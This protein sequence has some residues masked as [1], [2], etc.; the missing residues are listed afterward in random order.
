MVLAFAF[1]F[2]LGEFGPVSVRHTGAA[3]GEEV[4][5]GGV[6]DRVLCDV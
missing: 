4:V 3:A 2:G 6:R 5:R 1:D